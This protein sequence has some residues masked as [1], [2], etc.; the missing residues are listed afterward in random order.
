MSQDPDKVT[1]VDDITIGAASTFFSHITEAIDA[2]IVTI[3]EKG[4]DNS[5]TQGIDG[6]FWDSQK[7]LSLEIALL[8]L[9]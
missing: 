9:V 8:L 7:I 4:M 3:T 5:V 6:Q 2:C 1:K